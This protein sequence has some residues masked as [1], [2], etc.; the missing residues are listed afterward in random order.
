MTH[1]KIGDKAPE[2]NTSQSKLTLAGFIGKKIILY[3]Y[4]KDDTSGC[5]AQA[6]NLRDNHELLLENGFIVIGI[7]P[8]SITSHDKFKTKYNLPFH[9]ISDPEK[10]ILKKYGVWGEKKMYGKTY[11]G[12]LRTTFIISETGIIE[13]I[14]EKVKTAEHTSQIV[15]K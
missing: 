12:V 1:L 5:T 2:I 15:E 8:D 6:C 4:P 13:K 3:F 14:I 7:S 10:E 11:E 9:L